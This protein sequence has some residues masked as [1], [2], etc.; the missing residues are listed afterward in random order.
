MPC[1]GISDRARAAYICCFFWVPGKATEPS[2]YAEK[3]Q[4]FSVS[5][6]VRFSPN[7]YSHCIHTISTHSYV[8][9]KNRPEKRKHIAC[10]HVPFL[11]FGSSNLPSRLLFASRPFSRVCARPTLPSSVFLFVI[12]VKQTTYTVVSLPRRF[13]GYSTILSRAGG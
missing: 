7:S 2:L 6:S 4:A 8:T 9:P 11:S 5:A 1:G 10:V 3:G 13:W 12:C